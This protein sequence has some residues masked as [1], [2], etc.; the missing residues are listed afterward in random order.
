MYIVIVAIVCSLLQLGVAAS[1]HYIIIMHIYIYVFTTL[2]H[3]IV[4]HTM[5]C[6]TLSM[7]HSV[8]DVQAVVMILCVVASLCAHET[9]DEL[10]PKLGSAS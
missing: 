5:P 9:K 7:L 6:H 1:N 3:I 4:L 8:K 2:H 10:W